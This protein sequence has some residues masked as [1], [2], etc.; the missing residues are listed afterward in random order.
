MDDIEEARAV[1][2]FGKLVISQAGTDLGSKPSIQW[3]VED[4]EDALLD[5]KQSVLSRDL[6]WVR[7]YN[8]ECREL[9]SKLSA[10]L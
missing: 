9:M 6:F 3:L 1:Y 5:L 10:M 8:A 7:R 2:A 4:L